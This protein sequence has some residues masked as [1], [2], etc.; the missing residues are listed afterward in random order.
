MRKVFAWKVAGFVAGLLGFM[1]FG[2]LLALLASKV[3]VP[4]SGVAVGGVLSGTLVI[5]AL[6]LL[7]SS[8]LLEGSNRASAQE[9]ISEIKKMVTDVSE[10]VGQIAEAVDELK[11]VIDERCGSLAAAGRVARS[12]AKR[13]AA[14][15][16][17]LGAMRSAEGTLARAQVALDKRAAELRDGGSNVRS[18]RR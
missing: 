9:D 15:E 5:G 2:G 18:L 7:L 16:R 11:G 4:S 13:V 12:T 8:A 14:V 6:C 3:E 17:Q 1:T 10:S